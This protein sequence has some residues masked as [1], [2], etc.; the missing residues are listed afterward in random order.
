LS[1]QNTPASEL[2]IKVYSRKIKNL[3][4]SPHD[5]LFRTHQYEFRVEPN[6]K[7][8]DWAGSRHGF[9]MDLKIFKKKDM[10]RGGDSFEERY[11]EYA[12][13]DTPLISCTYTEDAAEGIWK[14]YLGYC[15]IDNIS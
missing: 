8:F 14:L 7:F 6:H 2:Q 15:S 3:D 9:V 4:E 11:V 13:N 1:Q 5:I 12:D 10:V